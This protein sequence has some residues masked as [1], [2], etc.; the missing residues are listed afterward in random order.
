MTGVA[1]PGGGIG[2]P[3]FSSPGVHM[4]GGWYLMGPF[5]MVTISEGCDSGLG[6]DKIEGEVSGNTGDDG[7]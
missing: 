2:K 5:V 1:T 3:G 6:T 7:A 4:S